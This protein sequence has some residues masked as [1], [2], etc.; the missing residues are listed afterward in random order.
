ML[1]TRDSE[2]TLSKAKIE[3][4]VN[5]YHAFQKLGYLFSF[6]L[7][8]IGTFLYIFRGVISPARQVY[9][10]NTL[11]I[12]MSTSDIIFCCPLCV[13]VLSACRLKFHQRITVSI[14]II[15]FPFFSSVISEA[16]FWQ[17]VKFV[18]FAN[19][20]RFYFC[21]WTVNSKFE[22]KIIMGFKTVYVTKNYVSTVT[23]SL[24]FLLTD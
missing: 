21:K 7:E 1:W 14:L 24:L 9:R 15:S 4:K 23:N 18:T 8:T 11:K 13:R 22:I 6:I 12:T 17:F 20:W 16:M 5:S 2:I 19:T 3:K 10:T